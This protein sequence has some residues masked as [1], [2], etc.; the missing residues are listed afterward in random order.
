MNTTKLAR[1]QR[2]GQIALGLIWLI[3]G[4]LQYQ[5]YMFHDTFIT[6][7]ILPNAQGQ[8]GI[9][10][11]PITWIAHLIEPQVA[12]F[13]GFAATLQVLIGLGLLAG[14]RW[15][16]PALALSFAWAAGIWFTGEGL[17]GVFAG[18]ANPLTGAPGAALLYIVAGLIVWPRADGRLGLLG[19]RGAIAAWAALWLGSAAMWLLPANSGTSAVHDAIASAPSGAAWLTSLLNSAAGATAGHGRTIALMM[20]ILSAA[21]GFS[22]VTGLAQRAFLAVGI[23]LSLVFWVVGQGLG[24]IFTGTATDISTAPLVILIGGLLLALRPRLTREPRLT[25][26]PGLAPAAIA[27]AAFGAAVA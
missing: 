8:P 24:G 10:A 13:N 12:L 4:A 14:R 21:I 9:I 5:P 19:E 23:G 16:R 17:G 25:P 22:I 26:E 20:A 2:A 15:V 6:G 27:P 11:G 7:V 3:D 18:T 1:A